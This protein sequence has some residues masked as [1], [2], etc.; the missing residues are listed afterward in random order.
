[1]PEL[2]A[3][4]L[5]GH[6]ESEQMS[7]T[8]FRSML[9]AEELHSGPWVVKRE[10]DSLA[11][12]RRLWERLGV[13]HLVPGGSFSNW[14]RVWYCVGRLWKEP[15]WGNR[16]GWETGSW[17]WSVATGRGAGR[18]G[19]DPGGGQMRLGPD[20]LMRKT[21]LLCHWD[22]RVLPGECLG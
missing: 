17:R 11:T 12:L 18:L 4:E 16:K 14:R 9:V 3:P 10:S 1:M 5:T 20:M 15:L 13:G 2:A 8:G 6:H 21:G 19:V 7:Q 22:K